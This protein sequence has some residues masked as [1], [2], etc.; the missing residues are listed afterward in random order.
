MEKLMAAEAKQF[1]LVDYMA[2]LGHYPKKVRSNDHL[3]LSPLREE[4]KLSLKVSLIEQFSKHFM[5]CLR[6]LAT[7]VA[8]HPIWSTPFME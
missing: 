4:K 7:I 1:D 3:F 6:R 5:D 2:A 8:R